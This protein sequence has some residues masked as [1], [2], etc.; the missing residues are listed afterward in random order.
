MSQISSNIPITNPP[1][2]AVWERRLLKAMDQS[3]YPFLDHFTG[4]NDEF[5]WKDEWGGGSPDDFLEPFSNWPLVYL[6]GGGKHLLELANHHWEAEIKHLTRLGTYHKEY[7]FKEDQMHQAEAD[8]CF[9]HLCL[10]NPAS[11]KHRKRAQR[12]AG[13]SQTHQQPCT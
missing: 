2:W 5:I 11:L 8:V 6:M 9:Y 4:D 3:V 7:G 12:F 13:F 1:T 10:A